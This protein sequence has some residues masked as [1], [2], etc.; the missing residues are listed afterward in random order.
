MPFA[1]AD[2][3]AEGLLRRG[4]RVALPQEGFDDH[5]TAA[6]RAGRSVELA[7][8]DAM[9]RPDEGAFSDAIERGKDLVSRGG[10]RDRASGP[11]AERFAGLR[12]AAPICAL[13]RIGRGPRMRERIEDD[14]APGRIRI[15]VQIGER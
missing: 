8:R 9:G 3:A 15:R 10:E 13:G 6:G 1:C 5:G 14:A 12:D 11:L 2:A 7:H 4:G